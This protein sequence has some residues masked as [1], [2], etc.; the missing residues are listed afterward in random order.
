MPFAALGKIYKPVVKPLAMRLRKKKVIKNR[1]IDLQ[2]CLIFDSHL[3]IIDPHFPLI[4][5]QGFIP[6]SFTVAEKSSIMMH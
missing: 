5:S 1:P 6:S 2:T 4:P 3:H